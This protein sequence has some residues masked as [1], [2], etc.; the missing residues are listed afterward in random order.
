MND[1]TEAYHL[2]DIEE[3][4][5]SSNYSYHLERKILS[6]LG[7]SIESPRKR[8]ERAK[9][10]DTCRCPICGKK[11]LKKT[12]QQKFCCIRCKNKYHNKR[13]VYQ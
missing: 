8:N 2:G 5:S 7:N 3:S 10:G 4:R 11:F 13:Q 6:R 12:Y 9:I 1:E